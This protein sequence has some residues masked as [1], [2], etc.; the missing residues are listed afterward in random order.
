MYYE[1]CFLIE[2]NLR[3]PKQTKHCN[4]MEISNKNPIKL[5]YV[6]NDS[7]VFPP[8]QHFH[9]NSYISIFILIRSSDFFWIQSRKR[10]SA[11]MILSYYFSETQFPFSNRYSSKFDLTKLEPLRENLIFTRTLLK[12]WCSCPHPFFHCL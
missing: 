3:N 12:G 8:R 2:I 7:S 11:T 1:I 9:Q 4:K 10:R 6:H 5:T